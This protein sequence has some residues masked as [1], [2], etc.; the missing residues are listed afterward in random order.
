MVSATRKHW[1]VSSASSPFHLCE[2]PRI[3]RC[4]ETKENQGLPCLGEGAS[5]VIVLGARV[6]VRDDITI[7]DIDSGDG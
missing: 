7:L 5:G 1:K 2:V 3:G 6:S 4:M